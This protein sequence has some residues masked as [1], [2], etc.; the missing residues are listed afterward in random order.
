[1]RK[2]GRPKG[3]TVKIELTEEEREEFQ[4]AKNM[5]NTQPKN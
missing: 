2:V 4:K 3:M 1:M 5:G